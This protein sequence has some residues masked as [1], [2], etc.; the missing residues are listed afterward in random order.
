MVEQVLTYAE[1]QSA[2]K[3][4][5]LLPTDLNAVVDRVLQNLA[6]PM[7][8]ANATVEN[9]I[10]PSLPAAMA[11]EAAMTQCIQNVLNNALK[12]GLSN[13]GIQIE[14]E[15]DIDRTAGRVMIRIID[16]GSGVPPADERHLFDA[17]HR[18]SNAATNTPGNG[19][20]LHLVRK[21]M[22]SQ[23]GMVN[24]E[25]R[26]GGGACFTLTLP[27]ATAAL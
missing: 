12:Y 10:D 2:R 14:I 20:G 15:S 22:E 19:L 27:V 23:K 24:Y 5:D 6:I 7:E 25:R 26:S 8:D 16:H 18:G 21:I 1:T 4:Y 9:R 17:F 3:R 11:D 13:G